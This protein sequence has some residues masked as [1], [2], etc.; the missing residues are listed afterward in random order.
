VLQPGLLNR[1]WSQDGLLER[2]SSEDP[3]RCAADVRRGLLL[4]DGLRVG[5]AER[6]AVTAHLRAA[7]GVQVLQQSRSGP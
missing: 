3:V 5:D 4:C 7:G 6:F 2:Q 1:S